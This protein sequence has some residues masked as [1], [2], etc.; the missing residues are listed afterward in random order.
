MELKHYTSL[1]ADIETSSDAYARRF[2]GESGRFFLETQRNL[3]LQLLND[4]PGASVLDVGG[5]HAQLAVPLVDKGFRL[6][7][8]GSASVC[9]KRLDALLEPDSF[10]FLEADL[11]NIPLSNNHFDVVIAFRLLTHEEHWQMQIRELCRLAKDAVVFDYPDKRS[12]NLFYSLFF[13][14]KKFVEKDTRHFRTFSRR[15]IATELRKSGFSNIV[16]KPQFFF[17]M[18]L[19]RKINHARISGIAEGLASLLGLKYLFGNPII[20]KATYD[21]SSESKK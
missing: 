12:F 10:S 16:F 6:C 3:T 13:P 14:L 7:V 15:Q 17:P 4:F 11:L 9:R 18:V 5:G 21:H 8:A 20:V 2:D 1:R 19:H